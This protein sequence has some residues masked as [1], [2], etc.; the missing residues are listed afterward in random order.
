MSD[1]EWPHG[2][3]RT[4]AHHREPNNRFEA[5]LRE[6]IDERE[7]PPG[8]PWGGGPMDDGRRPIRGCV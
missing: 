6:S 8:R 4:E 5:T 3:D 2:W 7:R 1:I